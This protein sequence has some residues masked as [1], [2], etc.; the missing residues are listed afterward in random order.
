MI[1]TP[2]AIVGMGKSGESAAR[3]LEFA[4]LKNEDILTFDQKAPLTSTK[5]QYRDPAALMSEGKPRT[6]VVSPGVPLSSAW[7]VEAKKAGVHIT[8]EINLACEYLLEERIIGITGSLGKSTTVSLLGEAL[9]AFDENGFVG[10]N[11]GTPF[12]DYAYEVASGKRKRA[13]WIVLELSS[14]QLENCADLKLEHSAI[15]F[16]SPNHMERYDSLEAYYKTKWQIVP[17]TKGFVFLNL[18]GGDLVE[19]AERQPEFAKCLVCS[20]DQKS[21]K[22]HALSHSKLLG[23]HNQD[24]IA[25]AAQIALHCHWPISS[26]QAMKA[27]SGLEHRLE[28]LGLFEGIQF[29]NDSKATAIDSVQIAVKMA[30]SYLPEQGHLFVLLGGKDKNLPWE[31]LAGLSSL[32]STDFLFFGECRE[33]AQKKSGLPGTAFQTLD[34]AMETLFLK[35]STGDIVLLSPGGTSFDEFKG[36]E[37][38]GRYFKEKIRA[39]YGTS[40]S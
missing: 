40:R 21:L 33:L 37:D 26:L 25:L 4:G 6:L 24:N 28:N 39:H 10:G 11:L 30:H 14:Y 13:L 9:K 8:S 20:K 5:I 19:F 7:I 2:V 36:F 17:M 1:Y 35:A 27:F 38:R 3:L 12:C 23:V 15:T 18:H 16:L 29:I 32:S 34:A 22:P 31:E